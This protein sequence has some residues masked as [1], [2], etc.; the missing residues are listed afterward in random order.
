MGA[1]KPR[2]ARRP[3]YGL[4]RAALSAAVFLL[5]AAAFAFSGSF[6]AVLAGLLPKL[7]FFPALLR[8]FAEA[9]A[10][11]AG[12]AA[13]LMIAVLLLTALFGRVYCACLCPFGALQDGLIRM[14]KAVKAIRG[15]PARNGRSD[16]RGFRPALTP[17]HA[18]AFVLAAGAALAG[19]TIL[20]GLLEP[21]SAFGKIGAG[22][23]RPLVDL[24]NNGLAA[25][26]RAAGSY[27]V[28]AV[29]VSWAWARGLA[30]AAV[31]VVV[32]FLALRSGRLFCNSLCPAGALLRLASFRPLFGL[33]IDAGSCDNCGA[34]E[35]VCRASC[36][37]PAGAGIEENRCIRCFD[38]VAAC[39][40]RAIRFG[41]ARPAPEK[42]EAP[43]GLSRRRF[44]ASGAAAAI[45]VAG[46]V[47]FGGAS[48]YRKLVV[49]MNGLERTPAAPPG[50]GS[51]RRF[52]G[53][54]TACGSCVAVCPSGVLRPAEF[55]WG[56]LDP[57]K[58]YLAYDRAYCQFECERCLRSCPTGALRQM[59]LEEKKLTRLGQSSL[60]LDRCIVVT[61]GTRCGACAEHCPTGAV[62]M[63]VSAVGGLP[64][65]VTDSTLCIGCGACETVCPVEGKKAIHVEGLKVQDRARFLQARPGDRAEIQGS[66]ARPP[67]GKNGFPF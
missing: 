49:F 43:P 20:L 34:C 18:G 44:L 36:V 57:A 59:P 24:A 32:G 6:S 19:S 62:A 29:T 55:Q 11:A 39:P 54:C 8:A 64:R 4:V 5:Y 48:R 53:A 65:P 58:P 12:T 30:G 50:A 42:A 46:A 2:A 31:L 67:E 51:A 17:I 9:G 15:R 38:C 28:A 61:K 56:I 14:G 23:L 37:R 45:G 26:S 41:R 63:S 47:L 25:L 21:F 1:T 7:Q 22:L 3:V 35:R 33:T 52:L 27:A 66:T 40:S 13:A 10:G 16:A 60:A